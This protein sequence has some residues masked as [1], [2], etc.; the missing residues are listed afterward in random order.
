MGR[1]APGGIRNHDP[2][3]MRRA[4]YRCATTAAHISSDL[5]KRGLVAHLTV[6]GSDD[7]LPELDR[8]DDGVLLAN[9]SPT[10]LSTETFEIKLLKLSVPVELDVSLADVAVDA[11]TDDIVELRFDGDEL[12]DV[13]RSL[14]LADDD[15]VIDE[16]L[17]SAISCRR[18]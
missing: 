8:I 15:S 9:P 2:S 12:V 14:R 11:L 1:E 5:V 3:V 13:G 16:T 7:L 17:R 6:F 18:I 4:L 10:F